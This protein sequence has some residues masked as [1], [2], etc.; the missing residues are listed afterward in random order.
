[1]ICIGLEGASFFKGFVAFRSS[2]DVFVNLWA[3]ILL[4]PQGPPERLMRAYRPF[5]MLA[6]AVCA[7]TLECK[8][9]LT[10]LMGQIHDVLR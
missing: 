3:F 4:R 6:L 1:M 2:M 8:A 5:G 7:G 10:V 9:Y